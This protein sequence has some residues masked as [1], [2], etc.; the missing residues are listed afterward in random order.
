MTNDFLKPM[1]DRINATLEA[2][3]S[4]PPVVA[5][6]VSPVEAK[7]VA[8]PIPS[9]QM[10]AWLVRARAEI[11]VKEIKG[12]KHNPVVL[13][14]GVDAKVADSSADEIPWCAWFA[15]AML[16][17]SG[18]VGTHSATAISYEKWGEAEPAG[19]YRPGAVIVYD[20]PGGAN[21]NRHVGFVV[22][23]NATH[24]LTRGG[25][26]SNQVG[27]NWFAKK[28]VTA[29]RWPTGQPKVGPDKV[30]IDGKNLK[31]VSDR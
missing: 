29:V 16:E 27:D 6:R 22:G 8:A 10:P 11:G 13:Q 31:P 28:F 2:M 25:N 26:Q 17:R 1:L 30:L 21:W 23:E 5:D 19:V 7:P 12:K 3:A 24:V 14:Y 20:F 15:G 18:I 9:E 4:K